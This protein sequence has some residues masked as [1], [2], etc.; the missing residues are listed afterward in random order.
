MLKKILVLLASILISSCSFAQDSPSAKPETVAERLGYPAN[1]RLLIIHADDFGMMHTIDRAIMEALEQHWV[2]SASIL[3]PCPWFPEVVHWAKEHPNAD[4]GVHLALNSEW[5]TY[6]WGSSGVAVQ[7]EDPVFW[8]KTATC[9]RPLSSLTHM[10][11]WRTLASRPARR[12]TRRK[13]LA[14]T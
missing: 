9:L 8:M 5:V 2:T 14:F 11:R 7:Q 12:S 13:R 1:S 3:V 6:R 4:L 10:P